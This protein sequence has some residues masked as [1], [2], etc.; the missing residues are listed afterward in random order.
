MICKV[1]RSFLFWTWY[2]VKE[3]ESWLIELYSPPWKDPREFLFSKDGGKTWESP[4]YMQV[5]RDR[6]E[7]IRR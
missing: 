1:K 6:L 3:H 2:Q 5:L 7:S 4:D